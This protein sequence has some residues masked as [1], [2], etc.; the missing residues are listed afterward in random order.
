MAVRWPEGVRS[1]GLH[2]GIKANGAPDLGVIVADDATAWAGVFTRNAA[3]A[4]CVGWCRAADDEM[5]AIVVNSGNANACTGPAGNA[6][7]QATADS[8][9]ALLGCSARQVLVASTGPIGVTL[10]P[11]PIVGALPDALG[12]LSSEAESFARAIITTDTT[13]KVASYSDGCDVVGVAKGAAMVAPGMATML[14][15][16]ATDAAVTSAELRGILGTAVDKSFNRISIDACESTNDSVFC[17]AT[18]RR[19]V[20]TGILARG[21]ASVCTDL[22]RAI[23]LD[24][25]GATKLVHIYVTGAR[26]E[27][28]AVLLGRAIAASSLWR[29]A[30]HGADPNW[31]RVLA[32]MGSVDRSL[33][34]DACRVALGAEVVFDAGS[35]AGSLDAAAKTMSGDDVTMHCVVGTGPGESEILTSDLSPAYVSLNA[36]GTS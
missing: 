20:D 21:I 1:A 11:G 4:A 10:D 14:A 33:R 32:A 17:I 25:E 26:D 13:T 29:A 28:H 27:A 6:T 3:A 18:G 24:A 9:A 16:I 15:F 5:R 22:A 8:A 30:L 23:A 35:P 12:H 36:E 31:G 2:A 19:E 34:L 7:V